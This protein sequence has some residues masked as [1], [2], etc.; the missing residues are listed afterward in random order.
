MNHQVYAIHVGGK[1]TTRS[2]FLYRDPS[3][4]PLTISFYFWVV[5]GGLEPIVFD[6]S[7]GAEHAKDR[8]LES[9][10]DRTNLLKELDLRPQDVRTVVMSHLHWDHWAGYALFRT[11]RFSFRS[12][13]SHSGRNARHAT[14]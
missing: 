14:T 4:E 10:R 8:G 1:H 13:K 7:F 9:Y 2:Q 5:L 11:R 6:V 12:P 3:D